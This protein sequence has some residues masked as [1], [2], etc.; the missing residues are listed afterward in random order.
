MEE[1]ERACCIRGYHV[2]KEIW[3]AADGEELMCM[4]ETDNTHDRYAVAVKGWGIVIGHFA[5]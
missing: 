5:A 4:R 1:F 2:Y 3:D